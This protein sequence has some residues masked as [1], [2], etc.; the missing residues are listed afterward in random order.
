MR[1]EMIINGKGYDYLGEFMNDL[2][3]NVMLN[4][5]TTGCGMTSVVLANE[6]KYVLAVPF[7]AL[8]NNK[9][10]WC[11][12]EGIE[13][14]PI[15][16][17]NGEDEVLRF[18]GNKIITTYDSI[19]KVTKALCIRGDIKE[20]KICIDEAHKLVDSAAF[21]TNAV[22]NVLNSYN[23]Y[24]SYVFGTATPVKDKYQLP[25]LKHI[26]KAKVVWDKLETVKVN[27][28]QYDSKINDVGAVIAIDFLEGIRTGNAHIF[29]NSVS[30]ICH[31]IRKIKK[32][33]FDKPKEIRIV[34]AKND[35]NEQIV[36]EK[37]TG[38]YYVSNVSSDVRKINFYTATAFEG[39]DIYDKEGKNFI[40]TDGSK[41]Y[42]KIDISTVL[43]QIIGRVRNS[44][45]KNVVNLL[46]TPNTYLPSVSEEEFE[47]QVKKKITI[48]RKAVISF[49]K[50][51]K[52]SMVRD[53]MLKDTSNSFL[54]IDGKELYV[55]EEAWYNEM[56]NFST[57]KKT[58]YVS[59]N[60][61]SRNIKNGIKKNNGI[62]YDYKGMEKVEIKGFNKIKLGQKPSFKDLCIDY[63]EAKEKG[64]FVFGS[65]PMI[66]KAHA[67]LGSQKMKALEY[68]KTK[69]REA[70]LVYS[71]VNSVESKIVRLLDL[72]CGQW[73]SKESVKL[74]IQE[75]YNKL[76]LTKKAKS[77]DLK[78]WFTVIDSN[79]RINTKLVNG[80]IIMVSIIN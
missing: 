23:K 73:I 37:L 70:L 67:I 21:R 52:D 80:I 25:K 66:E 6:V 76:N 78:K 74:K 79:R 33:G 12:E 55:N 36:N 60:G 28:C 68:R 46:F 63:I 69:I 26:R 4:K 48:A 56:H 54:L 43:P 27:Y 72:K 9:V 51:D 47:E 16:G 59:K 40:I 22:K 24:K 64:Y 41:D 3:E 39:C 44:K 71:N 7:I 65:D 14:C 20:W 53:A 38:D 58:Y 35:R 61:R 11:K 2:P 50:E 19:I 10:K 30:S 34:C 17:D 49:Y 18:A 62:D 77:T 45:H 15:Y 8:I 1:E 29:I 75:A 32:G 31:I 42:T 57:F 5:V 13:V